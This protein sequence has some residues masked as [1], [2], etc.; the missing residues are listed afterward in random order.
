MS[1]GRLLAAV[2]AGVCVIAGLGLVVYGATHPSAAPPPQFSGA[3][4]TRGT[5]PLGLD[6]LTGTWKI[7]DD[8]RSFVGYRI[9][10]RLL[11]AGTFET[12]TGRTTAVQGVLIV[13]DR[14]VGTAA[15]EADLRRLDSGNAERDEAMR[16]QGLETDR[17][18]RAIFAISERIVLPPIPAPDD[19]ATVRLAGELRLHGVVRPV[20]LELKARVLRGDFT[21]IEVVGAQT[22]NLRDFGIEPPSRAGVL[23]VNEQGAL[24]LQLRFVPAT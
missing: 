11:G 19:D 2:V 13:R 24:E 4:A 10:Q 20:Q 18:P 9:D 23:Q 17:H 21:T 15:V 12:V 3:T 14:E 22:I 5:G 1:R 6:D 7:P 8:G 16:T